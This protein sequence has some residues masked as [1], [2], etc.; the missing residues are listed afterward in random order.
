MHAQGGDV[1]V[2]RL[3]HTVEL[4]QGLRVVIFIIIAICMVCMC[5]G[6][7]CV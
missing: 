6:Y 1:E 5:M 2:D 4:L 3:D 7:M